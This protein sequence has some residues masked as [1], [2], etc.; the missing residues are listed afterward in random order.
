MKKITCTTLAV[1]M[2]TASATNVY[3][4]EN[5]DR[6]YSVQVFDNTKNICKI[7]GT[8]ICSSDD[9]ELLNKPATETTT[10]AK[11]EITT[12]AKPEV[13]TEIT[14]QAK[15]EI[16]TQATTQAKPE[17]TTEITTQAKPEITTEITTQA[18]PEVTTEITT[19][20]KPETT[21]EKVTQT[22]TEK[23]TQTTTEATTETTTSAQ[24]G[25]YAQQVLNLVNAERAK[26]SLSPL[27]LNSSV[28]KVAQAKAED[29][30]SNSYFS[31]T[32][33]TYGSPFDML[34]QFGISYS[35]AGEN[36]AKGQKTPQAVVNAWMNSE[37]HRANILNKNFT[38]LG[39]GYVGGSTTYWV[40]MFIG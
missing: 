39:V 33:P 9:C 19:Q 11:P 31:H 27:T 35:T 12:Q 34:K 24:S 15:P 37:G 18:K 3:A 10:Q 40:Q 25:S 28:S 32:S 16:T 38:Q 23:V 26:Y 7:L 17:V 5:C 21:T 22:T 14:T 29:M 8:K 36:I 13:T 4:N 20:A 6:Y 30:K 1:L 2:L